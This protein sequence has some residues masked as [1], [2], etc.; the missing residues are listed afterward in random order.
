MGA[1][2]MPAV[3]LLGAGA[4]MRHAAM[5]TTNLAAGNAAAVYLLAYAFCSVATACM[6]C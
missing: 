1:F 5:H 4:Q 2:C 3:R 6:Q